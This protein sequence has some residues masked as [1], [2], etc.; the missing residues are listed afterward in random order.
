LSTSLEAQR[1]AQAAAMRLGLS[2]LKA[3][4]IGEYA[5]FG[6]NYRNYERI[7]LS[8]EMRKADGSSFHR[9]SIGRATRELSAEGYLVHKRIV[10]GVIPQGA[11]YRTN[12]TTEKSVVWRVLN[13]KNPLTR[14]Q[15]RQARVEQAREM[16]AAERERRRRERAAEIAFVQQL[17]AG[18]PQDEALKRLTADVQPAPAK[19]RPPTYEEQIQALANVGRAATAR[20]RRARRAAGH[21]GDGAGR[22]LVPS[23]SSTGPPE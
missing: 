22:V 10:P 11:E 8:P 4:L 3:R 16:R 23:S 20:H 12:G 15:R 13:V 5:R 6:V 1:V 7:R 2:P 18:V 17:N 9:D 21:E 14:A 19:P